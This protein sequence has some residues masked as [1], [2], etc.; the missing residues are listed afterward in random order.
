MQD[1][2]ET[3]GEP[4]DATAEQIRAAY[5]RAAS[6]AHPDRNGGS[7]ER[8][9]AVNA[10]YEILG[11]A[12]S[13]AA[14]D[15]GEHETSPDAIPRGILREIFM[16]AI[17]SN[18][19]DVFKYAQAELDKAERG[20]Q[21][22]AEDARRAIRRLEKQRNRIKAKTERDLYHSILEGSIAQ[23]KAELDKFEMTEA[24]VERVREIL[25]AEYMRGTECP[26]PAESPAFGIFFA[27][28]PR[29]NLADAFRYASGR[30]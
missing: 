12:D 10:A 29:D 1:H 14:Y 8:M 21:D 23:L 30:F 7:T 24:Y 20:A 5:R 15:R 25:N 19:P 26:E 6:K 16:Q 2:Y 22:E 13:R 11:N 28:R 17:K 4:R 3:L 18:A 27:D 9:Q